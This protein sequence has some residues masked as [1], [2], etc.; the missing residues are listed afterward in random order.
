MSSFKMHDVVQDMALWVASEHGEKKYKILCQEKRRYFEPNE[1][2]KWAD[3][4]RISFWG[5]DGRMENFRVSVTTFSSLSTLIIRHSRVD[6]FPN[7][8]FSFMPS[9][10]VLDLSF[11]EPLAKLPIDIGVLVNLRYLNLRRT[12]I[13]RQ[14]VLIKNL[15]KLEFLL[16]DRDCPVPKGLILSLTSLRVF[17]W[18]SEN[19][20]KGKIN[21]GEELHVI[22]ELDGMNQIEDVCLQLIFAADVQKLLANCPHLQRCLRE[23][24]IRS[25]TIQKL[26]LKRMEHLRYLGLLDC[27]IGEISMV[28]GDPYGCG[29]ETGRGDGSEFPHPLPSCYPEPTSTSTSSCPESQGC[30]RSLERLTISSC[31]KLTDVTILIYHAPILT[32]LK[33]DN[34]PS[35]RELISGDIE[36]SHVEKILSS[37]IELV[38]K[39]LPKLESI[40]SRALPFP[41]LKSYDVR[42]CPNLKKGGAPARPMR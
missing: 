31:S 24:E 10:R 7:G 2:M 34:C 42:N 13:R 27:T 17:S 32:S 30:F 8:L 29:G 11:N 37:L 4:E 3:A 39:D 5:V 14:P 41:S 40:C 18:E 6:L 15:T 38:L 36:D 21:D 33:I 23:L 20:I 35:I 12:P 1:F 22:E 9:L 16:I 25:V 19:L 28:E 26:S